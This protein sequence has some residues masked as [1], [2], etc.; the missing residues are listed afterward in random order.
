M[1]L[2]DATG[3]PLRPPHG[4]KLWFKKGDPVELRSEAGEPLLPPGAKA[5]TIRADGASMPI[6]VDGPSAPDWHH[7]GPAPLA[8]LRL[9]APRVCKAVNCASLNNP[10]AQSLLLNEGYTR[11][12]VGLLVWALR[13]QGHKLTAAC[14]PLEEDV[15][16]CLQQAAAVPPSP[17]AL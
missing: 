12:D 6:V 3:A 1:L 15:L 16:A 5:G 2:H 17:S 14:G 7:H 10:N 11:W 13:E 9:F 8:G 4:L